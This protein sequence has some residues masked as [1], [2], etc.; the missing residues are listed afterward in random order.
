MEKHLGGFV[1][2]PDGKTIVLLGR[3]NNEEYELKMEEQSQEGTFK[4]PVATIITDWSNHSIKKVVITNQALS[5]L[6]D[7]QKY[8][9]M[10][11]LMKGMLNTKSVNYVNIETNDFELV[12]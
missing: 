2:I 12:R 4:T 7:M 10:V 3:F 8:L 9:V 6:V 5:G 11:T 1:F